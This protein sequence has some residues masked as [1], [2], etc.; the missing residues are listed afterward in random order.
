MRV[1]YD[2]FSQEDELL[3][4]SYQIKELPEFNGAIVE[5]TSRMITKGEENFDIGC[6]DAFG[7]AGEEEKADDN[8]Y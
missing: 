6:G 1:Y 7:G 8:K 4:D 2:A 5:V 3:S